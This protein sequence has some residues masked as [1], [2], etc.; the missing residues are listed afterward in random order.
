MNQRQLN[1]ML[2]MIRDACLQC[3]YSD[4]PLLSNIIGNKIVCNA[5]EPLK[6]NCP[7][8]ARI[9]EEAKSMFD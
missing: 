9:N 8:I 7:V 3:S 5:P 6:N 1:K 4:A 2:E